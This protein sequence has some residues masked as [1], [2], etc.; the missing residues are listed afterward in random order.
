M[1]KSDREQT[2]FVGYGQKAPWDRLWD[3]RHA[4]E[5]TLSQWLRTLDAQPP[6]EQHRAASATAAKFVQRQLTKRLRAE[7][8]RIVSDRPLETIVTPTGRQPVLV[9]G[10]V[11]KSVRAA[12]RATGLSPAAITLA[13]QDPKRTDVY[14]LDKA[15]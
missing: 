7:G 3:Q 1:W 5:S 10:Q 15:S 4:V 12:A 11:Y 6:R 13:A 2:A 9:N 8:Y 14:Y